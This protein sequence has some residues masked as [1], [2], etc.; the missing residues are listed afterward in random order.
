MAKVVED[1][2]RFDDAFDSFWA[3]RGHARRHH[4]DAFGEILTQLIIQRANARSLRVHDWTSNLGMLR[5]W[6]PVERAG[7]GRYRN[8]SRFDTLSLSVGRTHQRD[9]GAMAKEPGKPREVAKPQREHVVFAVEHNGLPPPV[10]EALLRDDEVARR[11]LV[12]AARQ[13][14]G[15][16]SAGLVVV[17]A[18]CRL[19]RFGRQRDK[20]VAIEGLPY[21]RHENARPVA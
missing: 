3:E 9:R 18:Y 14:A 19:L 2:N 5:E 16:R 13:A 6:V 10:G 17:W 4:C 21:V 11:D 1:S 20:H 12:P 7:P 15:D 8:P